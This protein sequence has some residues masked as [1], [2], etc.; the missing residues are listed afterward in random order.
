MN[1]MVLTYP[2]SFRSPLSF[3]LGEFQITLMSFASGED[4][5]VSVTRYS[6]KVVDVVFVV[7]VKPVNI[8][9]TFR[10]VT[11]SLPLHKFL[12][13][14]TIEIYSGWIWSNSN[15]LETMVIVSKS[16][17]IGRTLQASDKFLRAPRAACTTLITSL[18]SSLFNFDFERR[19]ASA[20]TISNNAGPILCTDAKVK[21]VSSRERDCVNQR[22]LDKMTS[23]TSCNVSKT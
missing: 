23:T 17:K 14:G 6:F 3:S 20:C 4:L 10:S 5:K 12:R 13:M 21:H 15:N 11:E 9:Y 19:S 7:V 18:V 2:P 16:P 22:V 8:L 1:V